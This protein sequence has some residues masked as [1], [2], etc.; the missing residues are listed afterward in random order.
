MRLLGWVGFGLALSALLSGC[1]VEQAKTSAD[2][3]GLSRY[4]DM[5]SQFGPPT[6]KDRTFTGKLRATWIEPLTGPEES[7]SRDSVILVFGD[8]GLLEKVTYKDGTDDHHLINFLSGTFTCDE[9]GNYPGGPA[10][11]KNEEEKN[12]TPG[13]VP[14]KH[15]HRNMPSQAWRSRN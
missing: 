6:K 4:E 3:I 14:E 2:Q 9:R 5:V 7:C 10:W 15:L 8:Q 12:M 11:P 1:L 13:T